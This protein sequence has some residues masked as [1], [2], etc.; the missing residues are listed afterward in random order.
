VHLFYPPFFSVSLFFI[1]E[2]GIPFG[3]YSSIGIPVFSH[4]HTS[5]YT[6]IIIT[7]YTTRQQGGRLASRVFNGK[8]IKTSLPVAGH[9]HTQGLN[10][11]QSEPVSLSSCLMVR[12]RFV[13]RALRVHPFT[14]MVSK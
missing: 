14:A 11:N 10:T 5:A 1:L 7:T 8:F 3:Y 12:I 4:T 2:F 6:H 13:L 9:T